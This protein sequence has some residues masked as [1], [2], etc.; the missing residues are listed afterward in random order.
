MRSNAKAIKLRYTCSNVEMALIQSS[1]VKI[2]SKHSQTVR[3]LTFSEKVHLSPPVTCHVLH[4]SYHLSHVICHFS[5]V[6]C[7][8]SFFLLTFLDKLVNLVG[9]RFGIQR[10]GSAPPTCHV[11]CVTCHS[12]CVT[13]HMSCVAQFSLLLFFSLFFPTKIRLFEML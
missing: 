13:C 12:S 5:H 2:Y 8:L 1:F 3:A 11:A 6:K 10:E 9:E 7:H 4:V